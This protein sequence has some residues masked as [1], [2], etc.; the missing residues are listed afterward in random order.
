MNVNTIVC[1][2]QTFKN[3]ETQLL[4]W[5]YIFADLFNFFDAYKVMLNSYFFI[6]NSTVRTFLIINIKYA[7]N[8]SGQWEL[9]LI[10]YLRN[11]FLLF[12]FIYLKKI[13]HFE[14]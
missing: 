14:N 6:S 9:T 1:R 2:S 10:V 7:T 3:Q 4:N 12:F 13:K 5:S 11:I 8:L